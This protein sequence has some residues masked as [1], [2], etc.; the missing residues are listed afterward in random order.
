MSVSAN[1]FDRNRM[2]QNQ[3]EGIDL[4]TRKVDDSK[5]DFPSFAAALTDYQISESVSPATFDQDHLNILALAD[6]SWLVVF[7]DN[8]LGAQKIYYQKFD[9]NGNP[10]GANQLFASSAVGANLVDPKLTQDSQGH[11]YLLYRNQSSG[12]ILAARFN[13]DLSVDKSVILVNDTSSAAYAGPFDFALY[14]NGKMVVVWENYSGSGSSI[15]F[16]LFDTSMTPTS[17]P[18]LVNTDGGSISHWVPSVAVDPAG[19]FVIAW[20]D[21][22]NGNAD[23]YLRLFNG[24]GVALGSDQAVV[25]PPANAAAQYAPEIIYTPST[26]FII[27][28]ID[29]RDNQDVYLQRY[30]VLSGFVGGNFMINEINPQYI[31]WNLDFDLN[32][33]NELVA[34]WASFGPQNNILRLNFTSALVPVGNPVIVNQAATGRRW[35]PTI[36]YS[37]SGANL[38]GWTEF[39]PENDNADILVTL[40]DSNGNA[41][42]SEIMVNDDSQGAISD[43]PSIA[44]LGTWYNLVAYSDQQNDAGDVFC[45]TISN[46]GVVSAGPLK[47]NQDIGNNLQ[48]EISTASSIT[49][50]KGLILWVDSRDILAVPGQRVFG[51]LTNQY[52]LFDSD[53]FIISDSFSAEVKLSP[54]AVFDASGNGLVVWSDSRQG[55]KQIY[56]RRMNIDGTFGGDEF[57]ISDSLNDLFN[58]KPHLGVDQSNRFFVTWLDTGGSEAVIK[59]VWYNSSGV[60][61]ARFSWSSTVTDVPIDDFSASVSLDSKI[62]LLWSGSDQLLYLTVLNNSGGVVTAPFV[63]TDDANAIASKPSVAVDNNNYVSCCWVDRR[64]GK[65]EVYYL[66]LDNTNMP[67]DFN[68]PMLA[69]TPEFMNNPKT[70]ALNGRA[71]YV[72]SDPKSEGQNIYAAKFLYQPTGVTEPSEILPNS[73]ELYQN[74]PNPFNPSTTIAFSLNS[75]NKVKLTVYNIVGQKIITLV[76][77][78]LEA[79]EHKVDWN[80]TNEF[81]QPVAS[82]IY[83]Y[84]LETTNN[85]SSKKMMLLK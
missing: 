50:G 52:G 42:T 59:T 39:I 54:Q 35:E 65:K 63:I 71:W 49:L 75:A 69:S 47:V 4:L 15:K 23:I 60:E 33:N 37:A 62:Y 44:P 48:S 20:E 78:M 11:I 36:I 83:L 66:V 8:R 5:T 3:L 55:S 85:S 12:L 29:L 22:R 81:N 27:G 61:S 68:R 13:A 2:H 79:G 57:I 16:R 64:S 84:R 46:S 30:E 53:E 43:Y 72:W 41:A 40:F 67:L 56:G 73:F 10:I 34:C 28:W 18:M 77:G 38:S 80:G 1:S 82:G 6:G 14:P 7:S 58:I 31:N 70:S 25:P 76:D 51:R 17:T 19:N 26:G 21:Y 9:T 32:Q 45:R 24:A 74:Y